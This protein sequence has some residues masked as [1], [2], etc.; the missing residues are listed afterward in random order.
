MRRL[1][2]CEQIVRWACIGL[3]LPG[4]CAHHGGVPASG[5][6]RTRCGTASHGSGTSYAP[7]AEF[8]GPEMDPMPPDALPSPGISRFH[9]VPTRPVFSGYP[10]GG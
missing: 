1:R 3:I 10:L 8:L 7:G 9:P 5:G 4:C 2:F 6:C